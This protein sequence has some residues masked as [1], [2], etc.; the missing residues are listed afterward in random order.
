MISEVTQCCAWGF[1][2]HRKAI[3]GTSKIP[4]GKPSWSS[5]L[6]TVRPAAAI[7]ARSSERVLQRREGSGTVTEEGRRG[8]SDVESGE[9]GKGKEIVSWISLG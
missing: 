9:T 6:I 5:S 7:Q 2:G 3:I 8:R 4:A 1:E